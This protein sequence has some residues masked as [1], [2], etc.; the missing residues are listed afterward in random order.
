MPAHRQSPCRDEEVS[1][2]KC[3]CYG[4]T[5]ICANSLAGPS[6]ANMACQG[7]VSVGDIGSASVANTQPLPCN[8]PWESQ[9]LAH[10][11]FRPTI[12]GGGSWVWWRAPGPTAISDRRPQNGSIIKP[13]HDSGMAFHYCY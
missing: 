13:F 6:K 10:H 8:A 2:R 7:W 12:D 3:Y 9:I 4:S 11:C 5:Q 1:Q